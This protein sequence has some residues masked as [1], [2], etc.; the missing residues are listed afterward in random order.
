MG[1]APSQKILITHPEFTT[2]RNFILTEIALSNANHS[3]V[4]ANMMRRP[5]VRG[6][7]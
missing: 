2:V 6:G 7:G 1:V 3:G 4:L 5:R